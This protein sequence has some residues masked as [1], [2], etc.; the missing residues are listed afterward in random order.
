MNVKKIGTFNFLFL[1]K[2]FDKNEIVKKISSLKEIKVDNLQDA[3]NKVANLL[4]IAKEHNCLFAIYKE[5]EHSLYDSF[6]LR[7]E[8]AECFPIFVIQSQKEIISELHIGENPLEEENNA[9]IKKDKA[10][11]VSTGKFL[12]LLNKN[13]YI[14]F[15][16]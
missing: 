9:P 4:L 16:V 2:D 3:K 13:K 5:I 10:T 15:F 12:Q 11:K 7:D 8:S 1:N 14:L 6:E